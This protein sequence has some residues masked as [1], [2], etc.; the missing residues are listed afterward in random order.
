MYVFQYLF[1]YIYVFICCLYVYVFMFGCNRLDLEYLLLKLERTKLCYI[2][3]LMMVC[4]AILT[5]ILI[6]SGF[7]GVYMFCFSGPDEGKG[8]VILSSGDN[9]AVLF[10]CELAR[11]LLGPEGLISICNCYYYC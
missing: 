4:I 3:L 7:R 9:P 5:C 2:K 6:F 11:K 8:F 10:Q 1:M